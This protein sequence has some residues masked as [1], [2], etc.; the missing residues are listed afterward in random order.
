MIQQTFLNSCTIGDGKCKCFDL[1]TDAESEI[2]NK[3]FVEVKFKKGE[4]ISKQ[5]T[6]ATHIMML[7]EG[8]VKVFIESGG[9][10]F[11]LKIIPEGNLIGLTSLMDGNNIF[12]YSIQAYVDSVVQ[13]IDI[14][15][16][17]EMIGTNPKFAFEIINMLNSNTIQTYGR[18]Y[19]LTQ[20][21]SFGRLA[22][23]ILCLSNRI[24]KQNE[25]ELLLS[26]KELAELSGMST[27]NV[28]RMLKKFKDD[29]L[30][31]INGKTLKILNP[32][33]LVVISNHG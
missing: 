7:C 5:G 16:I 30:I 2:V 19:C 13:I 33:K 29:K 12:Q 27:E 11:I 24:Y 22:D 20:K 25:F 1:L 8:L 17:K 14:N 21:Q 4:I 26:R 15:I 6:F 23:I 9:E 31:E 10:S 3:N 18:F 28:I 32:E